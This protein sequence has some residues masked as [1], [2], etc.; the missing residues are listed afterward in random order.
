MSQTFICCRAGLVP[1]ALSGSFSDSCA[2][3]SPK[4]G[5]QLLA[6]TPDICLQYLHSCTL[7]RCCRKH[8]Q[9]I[10]F[11]KLACKSLRLNWTV[12]NLTPRCGSSVIK[13][14]TALPY[15]HVGAAIWIA[16]INLINL[17]Q[18]VG[19]FSLLKMELFLIFTP[20]FQITGSD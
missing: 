14:H 7:Q 5:Q 18:R 10:A 15:G 20:L 17:Y 1:R 2:W 13:T 8:E 16:S 4:K 19:L 12:V 11:A 9:V 6:L 3:S